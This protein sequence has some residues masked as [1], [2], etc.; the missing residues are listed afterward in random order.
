MRRGQGRAGEGRGREET[1][2]Y[3]AQAQLH[4]LLLLHL[5]KHLQPHTACAPP[6]HYEKPRASTYPN[7]FS[8]QF[9]PTTGAT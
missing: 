9:S 1:I 3:A 8:Y 4:H 2:L 7:V 5:L 6:L